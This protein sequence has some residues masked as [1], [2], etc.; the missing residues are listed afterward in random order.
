[1][2]PDGLNGMKFCDLLCC[3]LVSLLFEFVAAVSRN[4]LVLRGQLYN[5]D[6]KDKS[7][8]LKPE[9]KTV[10]VLKTLVLNVRGRQA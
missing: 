6:C 4:L 7:N 8:T 5:A 1:M 3:K 9:K 10:V 2:A